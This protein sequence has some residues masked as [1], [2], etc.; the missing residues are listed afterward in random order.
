LALGFGDGGVRAL[1]LYPTRRLTHSGKEIIKILRK[2]GVH[3]SHASFDW[4]ECSYI[5][6][7]EVIVL[8]GLPYHYDAVKLNALITCLEDKTV[9]NPPRAMLNSRDKYT[10]IKIMERNGV[11]VPKTYL[12]RTKAELFMRLKSIKS[13]VLKPLSGSLGFGVTEVTMENLAYLDLPLYFDAVLQERID[14]VRDVRVLVTEER[15]I[16]AMYRIS[17]NSFVSNFAVTHEADP[18]PEEEFAEVTIRAIKALGLKYGG[19]DLIET[20]EGPKIIEVNPSPLWEGMKRVLKRDV[21]LELFSS[22]LRG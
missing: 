7:F 6:K 18:A 21:G 16:G 9:V 19:V 15:V 10:S 13:G 4:A 14:K 22:I 8:R 1:L 17:R 2:L 5:D 12:I 20:P 3:V 11:P